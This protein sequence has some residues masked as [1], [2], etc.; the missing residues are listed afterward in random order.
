LASE[1]KKE[2]AE[3]TYQVENVLAAGWSGLDEPTK[4]S[5]VQRFDALKKQLEAD[6]EAGSSGPR[7][8][9]F[10]AAPG[11]GDEDVEMGDDATDAGTPNIT[12]E[13]GGFTAVNRG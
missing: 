8:T 6:K 12:G 9:V 3:G 4:S 1:H 7:Q 11:H 10:D 5:F 2:I 13:S